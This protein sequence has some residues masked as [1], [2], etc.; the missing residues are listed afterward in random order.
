MKRIYRI[1]TVEAVEGGFQVALDGKPLRTPARA[2]LVLPQRALIDGVAAEWDAQ[3]GTIVPH[4]MPL[5]QFVSTAIDRVRP[6]RQRV[7]AEVAQYA[8]TDLICYRA[9]SPV[10]LVAR[11]LRVWQPLVDWAGMRF[12]A[13]LAVFTGV[14]PGPQPLGA[15]QALQVAI[16][17]LGDLELTALQAVTGAC[18]SLVIALA[19]MEGRVDADQ[20]WAASQLDETYQIEKWGE[21]A[22]AASRHR[23]LL[24]DIRN[25][26]RFL[27]LSRS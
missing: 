24:Q 23:A 20:A 5:M 8:A 11:Q 4:G 21:D 13:P 19:L 25:A 3:A 12:G 26:A 17:G 22:E 2:P 10:E 7:A 9:H 14:M 18:G 16:E 15:L 27:E 1:V 6:Q